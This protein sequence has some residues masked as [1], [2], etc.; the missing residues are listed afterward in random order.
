MKKIF[1]ELMY[2]MKLKYKFMV[3]SLFIVI[4]Q[5]GI[6]VIVNFG[7]V[8]KEFLNNSLVHT[9]NTIIGLE[10]YINNQFD[11]VNVLTQ[12]IIYNREINDI[13]QKNLYTE[14]DALQNYEYQ[15]KI[16]SILKSMTSTSNA[17]QSILVYNANDYVYGWDSDNNLSAA[18]LKSNDVKTLK[19]SASPKW[20][21]SDNSLFCL[22]EIH[23]KDTFKKIGCIIVSIKSSIFDYVLSEDNSVTDVMLID[24]KEENKYISGKND[25]DVK[26]SL[27][28]NVYK[29][30]GYYIDK[31]NSAVVNFSFVDSIK[32]ELLIFTPTST[33]YS[34]I[35]KILLIFVIL[36]LIVSA[37][38]YLFSKLFSKNIVTSLNDLGNKMAEFEKTNKHF[39]NTT[40]R[41]DEIGDLIKRFSKMTYEVEALINKVYLEKIRRKNAQIKAL[42]SQINPHFIYNTLES[43]NW[44]AQLN[45]VPEISDM[46]INLASLLEA[47]SGKV[48]SVITLRQEID[49]VKKY[50][51][52]IKHRYKNSIV[53]DFRT[54]DDCLDFKVPCLLIQPLV[55]NAVS[56]GVSKVSRK[57]IVR[58][59]VKKIKDDGDKDYDILI[60]ITDNGAGM[61]EDVLELLND[62]LSGEY[63]DINSVEKN[64]GIINTHKR[65]RLFYGDEKYG[66]NIKSKE[67]HYLSVTCRISAN[68]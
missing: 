57:G 53:F 38:T 4:L 40:C 33:I 39:A 56:H 25:T 2:N 43:I 50:C 9:R 24:E 47:N 17:V 29:N 35:N 8:R 55:E 52:I 23:D 48:N 42:Q 3:L 19:M 36:G 11:S 64:I 34:N 1:N 7:L 62:K 61:N 12:N 30:E 41:K 45:N 59:T 51:N 68:L 49:Y 14:D 27:P 18:K 21:V 6:G 58:I 26:Y 10:S 66:I 5:L 60:N 13:I 46:V 16:G 63:D 22:R 32:M 37:L 54:D 44:V 31:H 28:E 15:L 20:Y 67:G 65:I